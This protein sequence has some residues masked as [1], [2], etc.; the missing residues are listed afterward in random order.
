MSVHL[1]ASQ[2]RPAAQSPWTPHVRLSLHPAQ[3][4]PPQS[5]SLS[6]WFCSP[7]AHVGS[8][9]QYGGSGC[10][11]S[12]TPARRPSKW[13]PGGHGRRH[14]SPSQISPSPQIRRH[15]KSTSSSPGGQ[16]G[17]HGPP[18]STRSSPPLR[19]PSSQRG[20]RQ[21][22]GSASTQSHSPLRLTSMSWWPQP[23]IPKYRLAASCGHSSSFAHQPS[24][25]QSSSASN[26]HGSHTSPWPS[27]S[28]SC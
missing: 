25:S 3:L 15:S 12:C 19:T 16:Q 7:S 9:S 23:Q 2:T 10:P 21:V 27:P 28:R 1:P 26:G 6:P 5:M 8:A 22:R 20:A 13:Y 4:L 18:Q 17:S 11:T 24:L 14:A